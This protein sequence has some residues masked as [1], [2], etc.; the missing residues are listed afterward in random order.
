MT[1]SALRPDETKKVEIISSITVPA[2]WTN[3][4]KGIRQLQEA[5]WHDSLRLRELDE[6]WAR[7]RRKSVRFDKEISKIKVRTA[8]AGYTNLKIREPDLAD[9]NRVLE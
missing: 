4:C 8:Y 2:V 1:L 5:I 6:E 3:L 7:L 9:P